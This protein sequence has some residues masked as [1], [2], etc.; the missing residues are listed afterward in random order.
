MRILIIN[1]DR[2]PDRLDW[3]DKA[4][5]NQDL[6]YERVS[7][8]DAKAFSKEEVAEFHRTCSSGFKQ[9][10]EEI[11]CNL[12][13]K[14]CWQMIA[15]GDDD[16][17][18]VFEDDIHLSK[19]A[20]RFLSSSEWIPADAELI[21]LETFNTK[22][23][24]L[25]KETRAALDRQLGVVRSFHPGSA[26]YIISK[27]G[28]RK[29]LRMADKLY[30]QVSFVM[31]GPKPSRAES[32]KTYQLMP[33]LCIQDMRRDGSKNDRLASTIGHERLALGADQG[34]RPATRNNG[35]NSRASFRKQWKS[36]ISRMLNPRVSAKVI[37]YK[38]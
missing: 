1:L 25:P 26:G 23:E 5:R 24:Y 10:P 22:V 37:E 21:K 18:C 28:A 32:L 36:S 27:D 4:F 38:D 19:D 20:S 11:A 30:A 8:I 35:K 17:V 33:A 14:K 3:I 13:H 9:P 15:D 29:L 6:T 31:F 7:A 12:S 16:F 2:S 34:Q